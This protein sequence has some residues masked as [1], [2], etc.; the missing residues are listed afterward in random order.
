MHYRFKFQPYSRPFKSPLRTHHGLWQRRE[1]IHLTLTAETG[2]IGQGEIAPLPAFGSETLAQALEFCQQLPAT[3]DT[4]TIAAIPDTLPAC[5]FGFE[6]AIAAPPD[7][8]TARA[9]AT[10]TYSGLLPAGKSSLQTWPTL[11]QQG[12]RTFKWKIGV[13]PIAQELA[14]FEQLLTALP[15]GAKLRLDANGGLTPTA[16]RLWLETCDRLPQPAAAIEYLEQ[17]LPPDQFEAMQTLTFQTPIA[18]D[19]SVANLAQ[20]QACHDRGWR[21]V[22]VIKPAIFGSPARLRQFCQTHSIDA[23]LSSVFETEIGQAAGLRLAAELGN[24]DRAMGY[25][26]AHWF[27]DTKR[28]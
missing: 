6:T 23:V 11:W 22:I 5:Q 14:I 28:E 25:G 9:I 12:Y 27:D 18:L 16:A 26:I 19:E 20:L 3:I 15:T 21:G 8:K 1:G 4:D 24:R 13:D 2:M 17:P 10:L 7:P